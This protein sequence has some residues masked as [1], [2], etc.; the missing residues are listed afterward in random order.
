[1]PHDQH[2]E[3]DFSD[4]PFEARLSS[5]LHDAG[6]SFDT[7]RAALTAA[8]AAHGRRLRRR[9]QA[10]VFGAVTVTAVAAVVGGTLVLPG[11]EG[12]AAGQPA[13][14][15]TSVNPT[16][17]PSD[18]GVTEQQMITTLQKLLPHGTVSEQTGRGSGEKPGYSATASLVFD[19]GKGPAAVD[20]AIDHVPPGTG[21]AQQT[22]QCPDK[23][24]IPYDS[25]TTD[26]LAD[27]SVVML[28][29][30]YEYPDRRTDTKRWTA[31]LITPTGQHVS[32]NEWNA[33]QEKDA[34][35]SRATPPLDRAALTRLAAAPEWRT[36]VDAIPQRRSHGLADTQEPG[37]PVRSTLA[38]L[39]PKGLAVVGRSSD[40]TGFGYLVVDDGKGASLVQVNVQ[41][42]M[43]DVR[44]QLF[45]SGSEELPDGTLVAVHKEPGEKGG[46]GVVMW[47]VDS[48]TPDGR[49]VVVSAFNS[50]SQEA[51]ATRKTPALTIAQLRKIALSPQWWQ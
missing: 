19:D 6:A 5:A 2:A 49:R 10:S 48:M 30:G 22:V 32:V 1:M 23:V 43:N 15:G 34:P 29:Q 38:S 50:G 42:G 27:G 26:R 20:V 7:D 18:S 12:G 35:V 47:T 40:E 8:G 11:G 33:A 51:A 4:D 24:D 21:E 39:L 45:D 36:L 41:T 13:A 25:C 14:P 46:K 9:Q 37:A 16:P 28:L 31:E 44:D 17:K 3:P